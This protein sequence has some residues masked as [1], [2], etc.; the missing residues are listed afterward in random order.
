MKK[1]MIRL[2]AITLIVGFGTAAMYY[3]CR[4][5]DDIPPICGGGGGLPNSIIQIISLLK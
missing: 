4:V 5:I 2:I 3:M 1:N